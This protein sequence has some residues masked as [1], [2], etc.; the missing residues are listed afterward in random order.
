MGAS[1]ELYFHTTNSN[2]EVVESKLFKDLLHYTSDR[3]LSKEF[4]AVGINEGF[5]EKV[6]DK[7]AFDENGEITF[8]SLRTL[9]G[10]NID[11]ERELKTLNSD[12]G[13]GNY[14]YSDAMV[15]LQNFNRENPYNDKYMATVK[16]T[17]NGQYALSVVEKNSSNESALNEFVGSR[18]LIERIKYHLNKA[19]VDYEFLEEGEKG[20][21]RYSTKNA[22]R[23]ADGL[24][25]LIKVANN[26]QIEESLAEEAGHFAIG[27]LTKSPLVQRLLSI[28]TPEVQKE[29]LGEDYDNKY[30][31]Q[32]ARREVAGTLVGRA[33]AGHIDKRAPWQSLVKR[34]VDLAKRVFYSIK[35]DNISLA[36]LSAQNIAE[37][38]AKGF[39]SPDF[40]GTVENALETKETLFSA[41]DS[42]NV[43]KF[44]EIAARMR[45]QAIEMRAISGDLFDK[46]NALAAQVE[47]KVSSLNA[48]INSDVMALEGI[49]EAV[50]LM[51]DLMVNEIPSTLDSIDFD[52]IS[53]FAT[54][55][56]RNGKALRMVRTYARN[57]KAL[58][59]IITSATPRITDAKKLIGDVRDIRVID[60]TG[61]IVSYNLLELADT[62]NS[63]LEGR[64]GLISALTNKEAQFFLKFLEGAMGSKYVHRAARV[65]FNAR[66]GKPLIDFKKA[67]S[68]PIEDLMESLEG[69]ITLFERYLASM[70]NNS[71]IIG[72]LADKTMKLANKWS[73]DLTNRIQE[74][75]LQMQKELKELGHTDTTIFAEVSARTG[76]LTGNFVSKY[77]WGDYE[78]D[79]LEFKKKSIEEFKNLY[80]DLSDKSDFEKGL[81]WDAFFKPKAKA[82][83]K[84]DAANPA[85]SQWSQTE[86]RY[87]PSDMYLSAQYANTI[88]GK[89]LEGWLNRMMELKN[90]LDERLPEG[91]TNLYRMPQFKGTFMNRVKNRK[92]LENNT[93]SVGKTLIGRIKETFLED[94]EDTD[95]GS[96]MTYNT[97]DEDM[98]SNNFAFE[99]E[100]VNRVPIFGINKL[101]DSSEISTD[102][103]HS[104]FAYAGMANS[105]AAVSQVVDTLEV[106]SEV[107]IR[108]T[109]K[110][111]KSE[112]EKLGDKSRAFNRYTKFLDKQVYGIGVKKIKIGNKLVLNKVA[113]FFTG[114]AS[115]VFLGGNIAGGIVN[116]GTGALEIFKE[117]FAGEHIDMKDWVR[118]NREYF[119]NLPDNLWDGLTGVQISTNKVAMLIRHFNMLGDSKKDQRKWHTNQWRITRANP[120]GENL[121]MPYKSGEHYMQSIPYLALASKTK[122]FDRNGNKISLLNAYKVFDTGNG[123][124]SLT[125]V[126]DAEAFEMYLG[127]VKKIE[128]AILE[129]KSFADLNLSNSESDYIAK[130]NY[131]VRD[132]SQ[133]KQSIS[134]DI[135]EERLFFKD[136]NDID[137]YKLIESIHKKI[138]ASMSGGPFSSP[139]NLTTEEQD[140]IT[141]KGYNLADAQDVLTKLNEDKYKMTW[142][143]DDESI[144]MDKARELTIR[145]HG[146][147]NSQDTVAFQ[148]TLFGNMMLAMRGYALGF[149]ERRFGGSKYNT[150][151][152]GEVEGSMITAAKVIASMFTDRG[153]FKLTTRSL[154]L[155][156]GIKS[157]QQMLNAGFSVNQYYNMRRN[158]GDYMLIGALTILKMLT[159][160]PEGDDDDEDLYE[161][162]M[163]G[164]AYYFTYRLLREQSAYSV[165]G[166]MW[167]EANNI[168]NLSPSGISVLISLTELAQMYL[169]AT[170][171][172][173]TENSKYFYQ[174]SKKGIYE[175]GDPKWEKKVERMFPYL[176]SAYVFENPYDA[177]ASF[178]YGRRLRTK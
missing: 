39:M 124:K 20:N 34:I 161:D 82:W 80:P 14:S 36:K 49:A 66:P 68:V 137:T 116:V 98:F 8:Q 104:M 74:E 78:S 170:I 171:I 110:S 120:F 37:Q 167:D 133:L 30:L 21:G 129:Q 144:F 154:F 71:D 122:V 52:N 54:N 94:S 89:P 141:N 65:L 153:G 159:A 88:Q 60:S 117:A 42:F 166:A 13:A 31:G 174:S 3:E 119:S 113:G 55:M 26:E 175:V 84:G 149:L 148:Q 25:Q 23:T 35:G 11:K 100:K 126:R 136:S 102:L 73:D 5:L 163:T 12:I 28:L 152:G 18:N 63:S 64:E 143:I 140:Y 115:K 1:C 105:Y 22:V 76:G 178:E 86:E 40:Q 139:I 96:D 53:D 132:L 51:S 2:G 50:V 109:V 70:S 90:S 33:I 176:R 131:N 57:A 155:P 97:I 121:F 29:A 107:L 165:P 46:F 9:A 91:A 24:Y 138:T 62:L 147:Y 81:L 172:G 85:H 7:A 6:A 87:I 127:L 92:L 134:E 106:G 32:D 77:V 114:L 83:H 142:T 162:N 150:A 75:L 58:V 173:D 156:F 15:R 79:W 101:K 157:K 41:N 10:L 17:E 95:Y 160:K 47:S 19:G 48:G 158:W 112:K 56:P 99:R 67:E 125:F 103:F 128:K 130:S 38:I 135:A 69:D 16:L 111:L 123:V 118:A 151:L 145:M 61:N 169:G 108:R 72:Q 59:D 93:K 4:Y 177:A 43:K 27:A 164:I 45:L 168:T 146:I 44:K